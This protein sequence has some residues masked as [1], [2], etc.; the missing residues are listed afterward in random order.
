MVTISYNDYITLD[1]L[2]SASSGG[3]VFSANN[4]EAAVFDYFNDAAQVDDAIYFGF[5]KPR[6]NFGDIKLYIGTPFSATN[7]TFIWEYSNSS[8]HWSTLSVTDGTVNWSNTGEC[9]V[10][11]TFPSDASYAKI[12]GQYS[13]WVRC[14]VVSVDTPTEGGAQSTQQVVVR[15]LGLTISDPG[16]TVSGFCEVAYQ[17]SVSNGW[18]VVDKIGNYSY[19]FKCHLYL[20]YQPETEATNI[21]DTYKSIEFQGVVMKQSSGRPTI[22]FGVLIDAGLMSTKKG[23]YV[24]FTNKLNSSFCGSGSENFQFYS[25]FLQSGAPYGTGTI[26]NSIFAG[27]L[28]ATYSDAS[29]GFGPRYFNVFFL[30]RPDFISYTVKENSLVENIQ[31]SDSSIAVR[32]QYVAL[33]RN[34]VN[35]GCTYFGQWSTYSRLYDLVFIDPVSDNYDIKWGAIP[36]NSIGNIIGRYY[37]INLKIVNEQDE[38]IKDVIVKV[39]NALGSAIWIGRGRNKY[40]MGTTGTTLYASVDDWEEGDYFK[41]GNEVVKVGNGTFPK[42]YNCERGQM[43]TVITSQYSRQIFKLYNQIKSDANGVAE[44]FVVHT[45]NYSWESGYNPGVTKNDN[46]NPFT[47]TIE[48]AGYKPYKVKMDITE[49]INWTIKLK[50]LYIENFNVVK[51]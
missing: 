38:P 27:S 17:A 7:V 5:K 47:L 35:L 37:S 24:N 12:N 10:G 45:N 28:Y 46:F 33:V 18:G 21:S 16:N 34:L 44:E 41:L 26:Y 31:I 15:G 8:H 11:F 29:Q 23:C 32:T 42:F 51:K 48:K 25:S 22:T 36:A 30:R 1:L 19:V 50:K 4:N 9:I 13:R 2:Y 14:R 6:R 49:K 43:G 40:G 20:G 39:K 3:T